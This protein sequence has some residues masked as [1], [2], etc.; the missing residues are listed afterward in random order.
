MSALSWLALLTGGVLVLVVLPSFAPV[1]RALAWPLVVDDAGATGDA[2]YLLAGGNSMRE[3]LSAAVRLFHAGRVPL[4]L[5]QR[6]DRQAAPDV[7][8]GQRRTAGDWAV[9]YLEWRGVP[10]DRIR[11]VEPAPAGLFG[12]LAEAGNLAA[13]LPPGV[14]RLVIV[15][16]AAHTR[17]ARLAFRRRLPPEVALGVCAASSFANSLEM[18]RPLWIEYAKLAVYFVA[19]R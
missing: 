16:S 7:A 2:A 12:T 4:I 15:T 5:M 18:Y 17:R 9:A 10:R 13:H 6:D 1:R 3:R 14:R 11:V 8:S 19:A